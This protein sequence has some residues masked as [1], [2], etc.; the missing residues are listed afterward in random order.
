MA[1]YFQSPK[2]DMSFP[3]SYDPPLFR[4]SFTMPF[5]FTSWIHRLPDYS[6]TP[7]ARS[8]VPKS[9]CRSPYFV[10]SHLSSFTWSRTYARHEEVR[11]S[12]SIAL[13]TPNLHYLKTND[14]LHPPT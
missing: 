13:L 11:G 3:V 8:D 9:L 6:F 5:T 10:T 4:E 7:C 1:S 14:Q 12:A 2:Y